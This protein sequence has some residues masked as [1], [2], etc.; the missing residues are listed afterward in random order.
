MIIIDFNSLNFL[1]ARIRFNTQILLTLLLNV[2]FLDMI[3]NQL[4]VQFSDPYEPL[5]CSDDH[6]MQTKFKLRTL[7]NTTDQPDKF[8]ITSSLLRRFRFPKRNR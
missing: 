6:G 4:S 2:H 1:S 8:M 7:V 5:S 3:K